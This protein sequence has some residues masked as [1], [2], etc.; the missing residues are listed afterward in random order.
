MES[1]VEKMV[2]DPH[3]VDKM[4]KDAN[5]IYDRR[6]KV[7]IKKNK[8]IARKWQDIKYDKLQTAAFSLELNQL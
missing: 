3:V 4:T 8:G 5:K 6:D 7:I 2:N 1:L